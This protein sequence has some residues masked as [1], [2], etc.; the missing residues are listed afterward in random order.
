MK[1][2]KKF[3]GGYV[4]PELYHYFDGQ[5]T[6]QGLSKNAFLEALLTAHE[7]GEQHWQ[8]EEP[9]AEEKFDLNDYFEEDFSRELNDI[10][11]A[12]GDGWLQYPERPASEFLNNLS[13]LLETSVDMPLLVDEEVVP[14]ESVL[15]PMMSQLITEFLLE[16]FDDLPDESSR[17][18][19]LLSLATKANAWKTTLAE[20]DQEIR[21]SF[22]PEEWSNVQK[23]LRSNKVDLDVSAYLRRILGKKLQDEATGFLMIADEEM[24]TVGE[25]MV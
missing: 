4:A 14:Y 22:T 18:E 9:D 17:E 19:L 2:E 7:A 20:K 3:L 5:A 13:T 11:I 12:A 6:E 15:P 10:I 21:I 25:G 16:S 1:K 24:W 23:L 8:E